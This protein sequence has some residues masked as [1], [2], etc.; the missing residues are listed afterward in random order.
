MKAVV[1][2]NDQD[3]GHIPCEGQCLHQKEG[4]KEKQLDFPDIGK[5]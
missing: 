1:H 5:S 4:G 3:D 2:A